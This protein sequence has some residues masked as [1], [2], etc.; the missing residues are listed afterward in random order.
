MS[1]TET[2][3]AIE[4]DRRHTEYG[5]ELEVELGIHPADSAVALDY[6]SPA[7]NMALAGNGY[8]ETQTADGYTHLSTNPGHLGFTYRS[9]LR[10]PYSH[11]RHSVTLKSD[12][13]ETTATKG[14]VD[15][16]NQYGEGR[17]R[18]TIENPPF[19]GTIY[20]LEEVDGHHRRNTDE[21]FADA[22]ATLL[23][24]TIALDLLQDI[25]RQAIVK[26]HDHPDTTESLLETTTLGE[27]FN[28]LTS[29]AP[30]SKVTR[31]GAYTTGEGDHGRSRI[32]VREQTT[33]SQMR[34][35]VSNFEIELQSQQPLG[36]AH[37][38][39]ATT[40]IVLSTH[41]GFL[42]LRVRIQ[43]GIR[44]TPPDMLD[45]FTKNQYLDAGIQPF[46]DADTVLWTL[47]KHLT[48]VS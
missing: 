2:F 17:A 46:L 44:I 27:I 42:P 35:P 39:C 28:T 32:Q 11:V 21:P 29:L 14:T 23:D 15:L 31:T 4:L 25:A 30:A 16:F 20:S 34:P 19:G 7:M 5:S 38:S 40:G 37:G 47:H 18:I 33:A 12:I 6:L 13:L 3:P 48:V 36:S 9:L 45:E 26:A 1:S 22:E 10:R 8:T 43:K 24:E 41:E